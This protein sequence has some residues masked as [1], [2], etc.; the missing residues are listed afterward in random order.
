VQSVTVIK[1]SQFKLLTRVNNKRMWTGSSSGK[2]NIPPGQ[3][4]ILYVRNLP[5]S[6]SSDQLASLFEKFGPLRQIRIGNAR[7]TKG[8]A[9]II[10]L[11]PADARSASQKMSGYALDGRNLVVG[12]WQ[13][14]KDA[15]L[16]K[17]PAEEVLSKSG[18]TPKNES[19]QATGE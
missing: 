17:R 14:D 15:K 19:D 16:R 18:K 5:Y 7:D 10:F 3:N 8:T 9:Y 12:F 6:A 13:P 11:K 4:P 2:I 1:N